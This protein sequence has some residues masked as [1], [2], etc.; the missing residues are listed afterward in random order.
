MSMEERAKLENFYKSLFELN[1]G[2]R[3]RKKISN[4]PENNSFAASLMHLKSGED[5]S[6]IGESK[7]RI[8]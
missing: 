5:I 4:A 7:V 8:R 3:P 2:H 1:K 6:I